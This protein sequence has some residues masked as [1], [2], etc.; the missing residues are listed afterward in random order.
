MTRRQT[1]L[2]GVGTLV[3]LAVVVALVALRL[4]GPDRAAQFLLPAPL[5]APDF[6]LTA[7]D[8]RPLHLRELTGDGLV[9]LYFG[10]TSCPDICPLTLTDLGQARARLG[11]DAE[12]VRI[13]FVTVDPARDTPARLADYVRHFPPGITGLTGTQEQLE[14][15]ASDYLAFALPAAPEPDAAAGT[16]TTSGT[17]A[18][19]AAAPPAVLFDHTARSFVVKG[20]RVLM[21]FPPQTP[22]DDMAAGLR[23]L[24]KG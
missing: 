5:P 15:V 23:S 19:S 8:G 11:A 4:R 22:A 3:G 17:D 7:Q 24:L 14:R 12:R 2:A 18:D 16:G 9:V 10:Y 6:T 1:L 13:L 20:T 21:T